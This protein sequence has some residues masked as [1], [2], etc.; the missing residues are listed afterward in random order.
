MIL[1]ANLRNN[2]RVLSRGRRYLS[3]ISQATLHERR[4]IYPHPDKDLTNSAFIPYNPFTYYETEVPPAIVTSCIGSNTTAAFNKAAPIHFHTLFASLHQEPEANLHG[5]LEWI[6]H[7]GIPR[8][9]LQQHAEARSKKYNMMVSIP[10]EYVLKDIKLFHLAMSIN[11]RRQS[12][13]AN[14]NDLAIKHELSSFLIRALE[15]RGLFITYEQKEVADVLSGLIKNNTLTRAAA[16]RDYKIYIETTSEK[17]EKSPLFYAS[18]ALRFLIDISKIHPQ[19]DISKKMEPVITW[20]AED[21]LSAMFGMLAF[22]TKE[23]R[24]LRQCI[25]PGCYRFFEAKRPSRKYCSDL[26][27][28]RAKVHRFR[29][30]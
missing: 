29:H 23:S 16:A 12:L 26:C 15:S 7:F 1:G 9:E 28:N 21:P 14:P 6:R 3:G 27:K 17:I 19:Y 13:L 20:I 4:F 30:Q 10:V 11:S 2:P 18:Q 8:K 22:D 24:L 5:V 25:A